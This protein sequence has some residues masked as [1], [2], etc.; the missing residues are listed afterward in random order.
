MKII[1]L[2]K[3]ISKILLQFEFDFSDTEK[4]RNG[5]IVPSEAEETRLVDKYLDGDNKGEV[6]V[7]AT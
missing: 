3:P 2:G 7:L 1:E 6:G 4:Y 5:T